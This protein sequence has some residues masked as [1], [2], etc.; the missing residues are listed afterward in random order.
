ST[1]FFLVGMAGCD[2]PGEQL[3]RGWPTGAGVT[4]HGEGM[5]RMDVLQVVL[6]GLGLVALALGLIG[7]AAGGLD[8]LVFRTRPRLTLLTAVGLGLLFLGAA[9]PT[10]V[11]AGEQDFPDPSAP[12]PAARALGQLEQ[13]PPPAAPAAGALPE[14]PA[15][16]TPAGNSL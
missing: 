15:P 7:L 5:G 9:P 14:Q 4:L 1:P 3:R 11:A 13:P 6:T 12:V 8:A 16:L 2:G 10:R